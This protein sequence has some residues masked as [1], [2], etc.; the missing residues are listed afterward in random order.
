[1]ALESLKNL[2][3]TFQRNRSIALIV[4][5]ASV[6]LAMF[7]IWNA[8]TTQTASQQR[9]YILNNGAAVEALASTVQDNR[10]A[11]AK[12]HLNRYHELIFNISPDQK[13]IEANAQKAFFLGDESV[14]IP[15]D[16]WQESN[17]YTNIINGNMIQKFQQDSIAL[18]MRVFPYKAMVYGKITVTRPSGETIKSLVSSCDLVDI[19]RSVNNP[20]GFLMKNYT[21]LKNE[22]ISTR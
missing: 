21:V 20:N 6:G 7:S 10:E 22:L 19:N 18:N 5:L 14:K 11:E 13:S 8:Q 15:F 9:I 16:L 1:M 12:F 3:T 2:E 17:Y 4:V